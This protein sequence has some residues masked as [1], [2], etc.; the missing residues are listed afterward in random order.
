MRKNLIAITGFLLIFLSLTAVTATDINDTSN[1]IQMTDNDNYIYVNSSYTGDSET[2]SVDSPY[3]TISGAITN[4]ADGST[5]FI[6]NGDYSESS[7][8]NPGTKS[9]NLIGESNKVFI[10]STASTGF[11]Q[12]YESNNIVLKNLTFKNINAGS[13]H[14]LGLGGTGVYEV[15]G[16]NFYNCS[17]KMGIIQSYGTECTISNC[18]IVDCDCEKT[19]GCGGIYIS[20]SGK[21]N[22][23]NTT[24]ENIGYVPSTGQMYG[25]IYNYGNAATVNF[26]NST[27]RN[28]KGP[29]Y[30][31]IYNKG[32][33]YITNSIIESNTVEKSATGMAGN[34][35][36]YSTGCLYV[37]GSLIANNEA[38][39]Y[40]FYQFG[41]YD[42]KVNTSAI[43]NNNGQ[44]GTFYGMDTG[45]VN[46]DYNWWGENSK[47]NDLV[48][49]WIIM[50][51]TYSPD[52]NIKTGDNVTVDVNFNSYTDS[53][54]NVKQLQNSNISNLPVNVASDDGNVKD[55]D[56]IVKNGIAST[57]YTPIAGSNKIQV[58]A[59]NQTIVLTFDCEGVPVGPIVYNLTNSTFFSY[60]D[61]NGNLLANVSEKS[62][63]NFI[64]SFSNLPGITQ[65]SID[66]NVT[67]N[68]V[69]A[70]LKDISFVLGANNIVF[71]NMTLNA[72][73]FENEYLIFVS[74][75]KISIL[76]NTFDVRGVSNSTVYTI[77]GEKSDNLIVANN[78]FSQ[79][80]SGSKTAEDHVIYLESSSDVLIENNTINAQLPSKAVG[81]DAYW[82]AHVYSSAVHL[83]LA[84]NAIV[85]NNSVSTKYN[86]YEGSANSLYS[87]YI[88][89]SDKISVLNNTITTDGY[90]YTYGLYIIGT[91]DY[92]KGQ[93]LPCDNFIVSNNSIVTGSNYYSNGLAIDGPAA[94]GVVTNNKL[95]VTARNVTYG[96]YSQAFTGAVIANYTNNTIYSKANSVYGMEIMGKRE[97][98]ILNNTIVM[99]GNFTLGIAVQVQSSN[100][101][102]NTIK[103]NGLG[104][105]KPTGGDSIKSE[106]LGIKVS[107]NSVANIKDNNIEVPHGNYTVSANNGKANSITGNVLYASSLTGDRSVY[108]GSSDIVANNTPNYE[109]I[110]Y[111][112]VDG[113]DLNIGSIEAP[114]A[115]IKAAIGTG[116]NHIIIGPGIFKEY[117]LEIKDSNLT[118]EGAG[119]NKT[120]IDGE[121]NG[122]I[123]TNYNSSLI[124]SNLSLING[125][126]SVSSGGAIVNIGN[127]T[128]ENVRIIN[129][130][131]TYQNGGAIYSVGILKIINSTLSNNSAVGSGGAIYADVSNSVLSYDSSLIIENSDF[132]NNVA[133]STTYGGGVI[134]MQK[135]NGEKSIV[136]SRFINNTANAGGAIFLQSCENEFNVEN[137]TFINNKALT[138]QDT[139]GGG[140]ICLIG[141]SYNV[142]GKINIFASKFINNGA[143]A[144]FDRNV[145]LN[146]NYSIILNNSIY[147]STTSYSTPAKIN[148]ENNWWGNTQDNLTFN[149]DLVGNM[150][151]PSSWL[152]FNMSASE[153]NLSGNKVNVTIDL[154]HNQKGESVDKSNFVYTIPVLLTIQNTSKQVYLINGFTTFQLEFANRVNSS[155]ISNAYG[156]LDQLNFTFKKQNLTLDIVAEDI[157]KGENLII[158]VS[159]PFDATGNITL[160]I[161]G[162]RY[163]KQLE[164]GKVQFIIP[165]LNKGLYEFKVNYSGDNNYLSYQTN[166]SVKVEQT[167]ILHVDNLTIYYG[168]NFTVRLE[169]DLISNQTIAIT[170]ANRTYNVM[171]DN[172]GVASIAINMTPG[173][174][175]V[176]VE[177]RLNNTVMANLTANLTVLPTIVENKDLIK[178]YRNDSQYSVK[179]LDKKG[180]PAS[181]AKVRF[182]IIGKVYEI[183]C[184]KNGIASLPINLNPG[185][186]SIVVEYDGLNVSNNITVL[187][188]II[189]KNLVKYYKN[190]SQYSVKILD[191][192]GKPVTN[193][194][195]TFNIIGKF[196]TVSCDENGL[197]TLPINLLPGNYIVTAIYNGL[198]HSNNITVLSTLEGENLV[199]YYR[200]S[201]QLK[202]KALCKFVTFN[203]YGKFYNI[204]TDENGICSLPINLNPGEYIITA[205]DSNN[206]LQR[207]YN[208]KVLS[209]IKSQDVTMT[210]SKRV[211]FTATVLDGQGNPA[212]NQ[213]VNFNINGKIYSSVSDVNGVASLDL[214]LSQGKYI[215]TTMYNN[216]S[217]SNTIQING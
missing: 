7:K 90:G 36:F 202:V 101:F 200:N 139:Y 77:Y 97:E 163:I 122:E 48:N 20:N 11:L 138:T 158:N 186:Y 88:S 18:N 99:D 215:V 75:E 172:N 67:L 72:S 82:N 125:K 64:G 55:S 52:S 35:I 5:I 152:I 170:L 8:I 169:N 211:P 41:N 108:A 54:G 92:S 141:N 33:L 24:I 130:S 154:T 17:A 180:N 93:A 16:C 193:K 45:D 157:V 6:A 95:N 86:G 42:F 117:G 31:V 80:S 109:G 123:F 25:I 78:K 68:G 104:A 203:F 87:V 176:E 71:K 173:N 61:S 190:D 119:E 120:I 188:T 137:S 38:A 96:I 184:D 32:N 216:Q 58:K 179:V 110:I 94:D 153:V 177:Y 149:S 143:V 84:D 47:P 112:S 13:S 103:A 49:N 30:G 21:C 165:N 183:I 131:T 15:N 9:F 56:L 185:N 161:N 43:I 209:I 51:A 111:V 142:V 14:V 175:D 127:L 34:S 144:I 205:I 198:M 181:D 140:A 132:V 189:G 167:P 85:R 121:N 39:Q 159:T 164:N 214:N 155:L 162:N 156:V 98:N 19:G 69:G 145:D 76:N 79:L 124:L 50:S 28:V 29:S 147:R 151:E 102:G 65:I 197:C 60:F 217:T 160:T 187:S 10:T 89:S 126:N 23:I 174:Y 204:S 192:N 115:T 128:L 178:Y 74:G 91:Y 208:I 63:L 107:S 207:S 81:Y 70:I 194:N 106:N 191:E 118:I 44:T 22:I 4:A 40:I 114:L 146:I 1:E 150:A 73:D 105:G 166:S 135:I 212:T 113:D 59:Q 12:A 3:K 134:Y 2:G 168:S 201:S 206:G 27:I 133:E 182:Y 195:V 129:S 57:M 199:K 171:T 196:Y 37:T 136:N 100:I 53:D 26:I 83:Y 148:V 116:S 210:V 66:R 62:T 213:K 46:F